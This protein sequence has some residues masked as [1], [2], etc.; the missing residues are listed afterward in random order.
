M[1]YKR[2]CARHAS[3][4][5][6]S[7]LLYI[8]KGLIGSTLQPRSAD[9]RGANESL[10]L[11]FHSG[12]IGYNQLEFSSSRSPRKSQ[13]PNYYRLQPELQ[14]NGKQ[15]SKNTI[16]NNNGTTSNNSMYQ[17]EPK[18]IRHYL[19]ASDPNHACWQ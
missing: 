19:M 15:P 11:I 2:S 8:N 16:K 13:P 6:L 18:L 14:Q 7:P 4:N 9:H 17:I 5:R 1:L 10:C 3:N 12:S